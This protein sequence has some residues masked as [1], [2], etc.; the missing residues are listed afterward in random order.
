MAAL[1]SQVVCDVSTNKLRNVAK[2][3]KDS[4]AANQQPECLVI[5]NHGIR[6]P[7]AVIQNDIMHRPIAGVEL[8]LQSR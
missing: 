5:E 3:L 6:Q 7:C 1:Q 4:M 2:E 8:L